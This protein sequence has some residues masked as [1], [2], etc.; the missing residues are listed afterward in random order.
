MYKVLQIPYMM[1]Q[2]HVPGQGNLNRITKTVP[3]WQQTLMLL[4]LIHIVSSASLLSSSLVFRAIFHVPYVVVPRPATESLAS[5][6]TPHSSD[7]SCGRV[8]SR[9]MREL[10]FGRFIIKFE[11]ITQLDNIGQGTS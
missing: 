4:T 10:S 8:N 11:N 5:G 6:N 2:L 9:Y 3:C 7:H 1:H